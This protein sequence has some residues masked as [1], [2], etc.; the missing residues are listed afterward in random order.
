M[1]A[2]VHRRFLDYRERH[3]YFAKETSAQCLTYE[4]FMPVDAEER[5]LDARGPARDDDEEER[6]VVLRR[7]LFR[8]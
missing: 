4:E 8:D 2:L 5:S 3:L 6:F 7:L 1:D